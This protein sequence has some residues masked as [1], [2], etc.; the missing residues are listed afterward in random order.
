M[1]VAAT[2]NL[3][4]TVGGG[5]QIGCDS[6]DPLHDEAVDPASAYVEAVVADEVGSVREDGTASMAAV[7]IVEQPIGPRTARQ[8]RIVVRGD[9]QKWCARCRAHVPIATKETVCLGLRPVRARIRALA[10]SSEQ[11]RRCMSR[12]QGHGS[13]LSLNP[14]R[15]RLSL[16]FMTTKVGAQPIVHCLYTGCRHHLRIRARVMCTQNLLVS[17]DQIR[18]YGGCEQQVEQHRRVRPQLL[19]LLRLDVSKV[20]TAAQEEVRAYGGALLRVQARE[21]ATDAVAGAEP[22]NVD[23]GVWV[24]CGDVIDGHLEVS[25]VAK[26]VDDR[27][28]E[29]CRNTTFEEHSHTPR[30][31]EQLPIDVCAR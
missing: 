29:R 10:V 18:L 11:L 8:D 15:L 13:G 12:G 9:L 2:R 20:G 24:S 27:R 7:C 6:V 21:R 5:L 14:C 31:F 19:W 22:N 26:D 4:G 17:S 16:A 3:L 1:I 25:R 30:A 23:G 28:T